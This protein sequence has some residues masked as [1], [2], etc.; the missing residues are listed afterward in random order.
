MELGVAVHMA[1]VLW[2]ETMFQSTSFPES[3]E[4]C[5]FSK[6][7]SYKSKGKWAIFRVLGQS[8]P[9]VKWKD[10]E[11]GKGCLLKGSSLELKITIFTYLCKP[12][13]QGLLFLFIL[14]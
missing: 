2:D 4:T 14:E 7:S 5:S 12:K 1:S 13:S 6:T 8:F 10:T 3:S 11:V 9:W